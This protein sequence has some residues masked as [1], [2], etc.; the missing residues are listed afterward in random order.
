MAREYYWSLLHM[1]WDCKAETHIIGV[2]GCLDALVDGVIGREHLF[3][4]VEVC[5]KLCIAICEVEGIEIEVV[6]QVLAG[7]DKWRVTI[8]RYEAVSVSQKG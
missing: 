2:E 6:R 7:I 3:I 5:R 4:R 8:G 1:R